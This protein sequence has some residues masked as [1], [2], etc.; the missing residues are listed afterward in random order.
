ML[1]WLILDSRLRVRV[2]CRMGPA[3]RTALAASCNDLVIPRAAD[4]KKFRFNL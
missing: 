4:D 3:I 1:P 2:D